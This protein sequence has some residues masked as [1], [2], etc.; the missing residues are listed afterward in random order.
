[1]SSSELIVYYSAIIE[2]HLNPHPFFRK[3]FRFW[4]L[5]LCLVLTFPS[6]SIVNSLNTCYTTSLPSAIIFLFFFSFF[7]FASSAASFLSF[8]RPFP[9]VRPSWSLY[10]KM[11]F[12]NGRFSPSKYAS[13]ISTRHRT[14]PV[15]GKEG[16]YDG[17]G[18][19]KTERQ[20]KVSSIYGKAITLRSALGMHA[21]LATI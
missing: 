12:H 20:K 21:I 18:E 14:P 10:Q 3:R 7:L 16:G 8:S 1:M 17:K 11:P 13:E 19:K 2:D 15:G 5:A 6:S 4:S 9:S